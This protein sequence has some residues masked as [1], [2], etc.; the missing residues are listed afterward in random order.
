MAL[1]NLNIKSFKKDQGGI[2]NRLIDKAINKVEQKL[3]NAVEDAFAKGL[4]KVGL[5]DSVTGE[6]S[7]RFGD[8][9]SNGRADDFF[10]SST[11]EQ[12]RVSPKEIEENLLA[13]KNA[14]T[15]LDAVQKINESSIKNSEVMQ[16]PDQMGKYYMSLDFQSYER[17]SPQMAAVFKRFRT[18]QLPI[19]RD[20]KEN[21]D[22]D[23]NPK[24][25]GAKAGG[26]AD[27][28]V[29]LLRGAGTSVQGTE[30]AI[31]Y[32]ALA[33]AFEGSAAD[34]LG[35]ALGAVPNPHLQA[36][37]SGVDLRTHTFQWTFAPRNPQESRN[38][39]AII[40]EIKKN[41]LPDYS[42]T[43]TAALQYPPMVEIRL[44]PWGD[45][46]IKFK[47]CLIKSVSINYA[48]AGLP[49]FF[50]GTR[51][52]TMIQLELQMLETEIQTA[53][54]YGLTSGERE[55][56]LEQFKDALEKGADRL[57]LTPVI[58]AAKE[59]TRSVYQGV[60]QGTGTSSI[61]IE[62]GVRK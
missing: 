12:N 41:S 6:L 34:A 48:P 13:V 9:F 44:M 16:F 17:P 51:E 52:P 31:L 7:A 21:F 26:L 10:K 54:D 61:G 60:S 43:G 22:L 45:D 62:P 24:A 38:L 57:G 36:L 58:E 29:D 1:I 2:A 15:T 19:P 23:V 40:K 55:D 39:K 8:A 37:F 49:S 35:Q 28:G 14:E 33:Q 59:T 3:E 46:L 42:T 11:A 18:I 25:L 30:F 27:L 53:R 32:G 5:S 20:L 50:A 56:K 4:K 47:K